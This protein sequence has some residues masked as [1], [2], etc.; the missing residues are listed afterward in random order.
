MVCI[1]YH[2]FVVFIVLDVHANLV[3][4]L[5]PLLKGHNVIRWI[6]VA[7]VIVLLESVQEVVENFFFT[8]SAK[9]DIWVLACVISALDV[10]NVEL[11]V[12]VCIHCLVGTNSPVSSE[13]VHL[14]NN[15]AQELFI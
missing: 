2:Y 4:V 10:R 1:S 9:H 3:L 14:S 11:A 7:Q 8:P 6:L 5:K 13:L 15:R 12:P